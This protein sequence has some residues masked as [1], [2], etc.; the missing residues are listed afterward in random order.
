MSARVAVTIPCFEE[1][2]LVLE[3]ARS[4]QEDEPVEIVVVD[5]ASRDAPT[6]RALD[7]LRSEGVAVVTHAENQGL[8]GARMTVRSK[9]TCACSRFARS[10]A[11]CA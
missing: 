7:E 11:A 9:L 5:D 6:A 2:E 8:I 1:G 3:A 10:T 4:V